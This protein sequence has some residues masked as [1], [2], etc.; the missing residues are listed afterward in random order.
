MVKSEKGVRAMGLSQSVKS[1]ERSGN[2]SGRKPIPRKKFIGDGAAKKRGRKKFRPLPLCEYRPELVPESL[3]ENFKYP[4]WTDVSFISETPTTITIRHRDGE[5]LTI[6]KRTP[7]RRVP[8]KKG[9][10]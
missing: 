6:P 8:K 9:R 5:I 1:T 4:K 2:S 10:A 3:R 7:K